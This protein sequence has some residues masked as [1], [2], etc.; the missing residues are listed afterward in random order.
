MKEAFVL[1]RCEPGHEEDVVRELQKIDQV[2][3]IRGI[4]G[5]YDLLVKLEVSN[6]SKAYETA[7]KKILDVG[8]VCSIK[9]LTSTSLL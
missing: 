3:E 5:E 9:A 2:R 4:I 1:I 6:E 7:N 8:K